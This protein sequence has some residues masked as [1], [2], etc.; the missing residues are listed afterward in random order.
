MEF[1]LEND[2]YDFYN[3]S[4]NEVGFNIQISK[5]NMGKDGRMLDRI[6]CCSFEGYCGKDKRQYK[7][8]ALSAS[9]KIW[10]FCENQ[11]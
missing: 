1:D 2:A 7:C 4:A 6:L 9:N 3:K 8:Q 10:V 11:N 5:G